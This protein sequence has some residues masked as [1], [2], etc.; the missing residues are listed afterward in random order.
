M[1]MIARIY[2]PLLHKSEWPKV[3][4]PNLF[5][6]IP[7]LLGGA[8]ELYGMAMAAAYVTALRLDQPG[9]SVHNEDLEGRNP[10]W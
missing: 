3:R 7:R 2:V 10:D 8:L 6:D 1:Q 9:K 4:I 5:R